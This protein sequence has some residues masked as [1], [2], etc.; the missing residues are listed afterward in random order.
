MAKCNS[1]RCHCPDCEEEKREQ[2]Q[3]LRLTSVE[4]R[5]GALERAARP[6]T[7]PDHRVRVFGAETIH[8]GPKGRVYR[9]Y[10]RDP[11]LIWRWRMWDKNPSFWRKWDIDRACY[12]GAPWKPRYGYLP[13]HPQGAREYSEH[14]R[15]GEIERTKTVRF[16]GN[17]EPNESWVRDRFLRETAPVIDAKDGFTPFPGKQDEFF[18]T[19]SPHKLWARGGFWPKSYGTRASQAEAGLYY[20][21]PTKVGVTLADAAKF[22]TSVEIKPEGNAMSPIMLEIMLHAHYSCEAFHRW[23][24]PIYGPSVRKLKSLGLIENTENSERGTSGWTIKATEK[25][26]VYVAALLATPMPIKP[27]PEWRMPS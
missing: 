21:G 5:V 20:D 18:R 26:K 15:V 24:A 11:N 22:M 12:F 4:H 2:T 25:G 23:H 8:R 13:P 14:K 19:P 17:P 6:P 16:E 7:H 1:N 3:N 27:E 10:S 9:G